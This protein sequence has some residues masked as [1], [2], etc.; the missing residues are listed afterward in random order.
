MITKGHLVHLYIF[1]PVNMLLLIHIKGYL[2]VAWTVPLTSKFTHSC[3]F[4]IV[5]F[6]WSVETCMSHASETW[7]A[8]CKWDLV[9]YT[10]CEWDLVC[11]MG[12]S[13]IPNLVCLYFMILTTLLAKKCNAST[14]PCLCMWCGFKVVPTKNYSTYTRIFFTTY[15]ML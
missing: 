13:D 2:K 12:V 4:M 5:F 6:K 1:D 9:C 8:A 14:V 11:Y 15:V 3:T 7:C 10:T